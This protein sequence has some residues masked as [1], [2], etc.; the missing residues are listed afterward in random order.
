MVSGGI[1]DFLSFGTITLQN[2]Q[3]LE[4][5]FVLFIFSGFISFC[6]VDCMSKLSPCAD[7][8]IFFFYPFPENIDGD[9]VLFF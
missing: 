6:L 1:D 3:F 9:I 4:R 2:N 7:D 8:Y 5:A